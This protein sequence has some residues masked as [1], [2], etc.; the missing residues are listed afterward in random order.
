MIAP[1]SLFKLQDSLPRF[2]IVCFCYLLFVTSVWS[3]E[4]VTDGPRVSASEGRSLS[5]EEASQIQAA[6]AKALGVSTHKK[7]AINGAE[8]EFQLIPAGKFIV[9][10]P[11]SEP[12]RDNEEVQLQASISKSFYM[13][14]YEV[15]N[16]QWDAITGAKS[17][18]AGEEGNL[19]KVSICWS[20]IDRKFMPKIKLLVENATVS[21]PTELQWEYACRAGT[22]TAFNWGTNTITSDQA[23]YNGGKVYA[24]GSEGIDRAR[25]IKVGSFPSN[26]WGLHDMHGNVSEWCKDKHE[27]YPNPL[28]DDYCKTSPYI[29]SYIARGGNYASWPENLRSAKRY[30]DRDFPSIM[31]GFRLVMTIP[32]EQGTEVKAATP[33]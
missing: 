25:P 14:A 6:A 20:D 26:A 12:M 17:F 30:S 29:A 22:I 23:N 8:F 16:R 11:P 18:V 7:M 2:L 28:P 1:E 5:N 31:R 33:K 3:E 9:G 19:P 32:A 24:G 27:E 21:L 13:G 15:T 4:A 10:S